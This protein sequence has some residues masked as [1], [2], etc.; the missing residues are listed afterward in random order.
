MTDARDDI[1]W[2]QRRLLDFGEIILGIAVELQH[3]DLDQ[4][5]ILVRPH[6][7]EVEGIVPMLVDVRLRHDLDG[8][9]PLWEIAALDRLI[10]VALM[11]LAIVGDFLR[12]FG[13][14]PVLDALESL[15]VEFYPEPLVLRIDERVGVRAEAVDVAIALRQPAIRHQDCHLMQTFRRQRPEIPHGGR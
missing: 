10:E 7:G 8:E 11:R 1:G 4:G 14:G 5:I 12:R 13:I 15:E 6:L 9:F 2:R 3:A